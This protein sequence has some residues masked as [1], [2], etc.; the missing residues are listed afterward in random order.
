MRVGVD[1]MGTLPQ[2]FRACRIEVELSSFGKVGTVTGIRFHYPTWDGLLEPG[3]VIDAH[4][5]E[6]CN[7]LDDHELGIQ[8]HGLNS[9]ESW[10]GTLSYLRSPDSDYLWYELTWHDGKKPP[11]FRS[12]FM[13]HKLLR[14][15]W[16]LLGGTSKSSGR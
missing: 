7:L 10:P 12:T 3:T 9:R 16:R 14:W 5:E 8:L 13:E 2:H 15:L 11:E 4:Q 1:T 6:I